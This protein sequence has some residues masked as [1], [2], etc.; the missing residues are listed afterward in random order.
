[1]NTS[2]STALA[3]IY[4]DSARMGQEREAYE[5][6]LRAWVES[7]RRKL[8]TGSFRPKIFDNYVCVLIPMEEWGYQRVKQAAR[9]RLQQYRCQAHGVFDFW[10]S[11]LDFDKDTEPQCYRCLDECR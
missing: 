2:G 1:M 8:C 11:D 4:F 5:A 9:F 10:R 7:I 6:K 3:F